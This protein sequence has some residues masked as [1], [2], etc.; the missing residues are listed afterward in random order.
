MY[1]S[2]TIKTKQPYPV[3]I[4]AG[5][6]KHCGEII[7]KEIKPGRAALIADEQV[8]ALYG[9]AVKA[10]LE[11]SGFRVYSFTFPPGEGSKTPETLLKIMNFLAENQFSRSEPAIALGGGVCGDLAGFAAAC[12]LRG[13]ELVQL[14]TSL[15]AMV[16]ASVGGKTAVDLPQGKNL[17]GAFKQPRTVICDPKLLET[18]PDNEFSA[19]MA[20][21][22]K[23]ALMADKKLFE[24]LEK[25]G[26]RQ[27]LSQNALEKIISRCIEIKG[28]IVAEDELDLGARHKLNLGHTIGHAI[29]IRS[30][31]SLNHGEAVA[32]GMYMICKAAEKIG[33]CET[34]TASRL[35][36]VLNTFNLPTSTSY[37]SKELA[38]FVLS[39][40]K[41]SGDSIDFV[42]PKQVGNCFCKSV[43]VSEIEAIIDLGRGE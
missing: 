26:G 31:Y 41:R 24:A 27:G 33:H 4:G 36:H 37:D 42:F 12:Y 1:S 20:E 43:A 18:L 30:S 11:A 25:S 16:D 15:L 35:K 39:D 23:Y 10:S 38:Q 32:I 21:V 5:A 34:G 2:L 3:F 22:I 40:K 14:P 28:E 13:M 6:I 9:K 17:M 7:S 8:F 29:E 19:G